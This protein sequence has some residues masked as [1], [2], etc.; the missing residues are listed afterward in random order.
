M[1]FDSGIPFTQLQ[2]MHIED[3]LLVGNR[4]IQFQQ[5]STS[6]NWEH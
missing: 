4:R 5:Q 6:I 2:S 3:N 1:N